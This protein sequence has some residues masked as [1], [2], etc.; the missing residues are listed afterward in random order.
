MARSVRRGLT[1]PDI[2]AVRDRLVPECTIAA[3]FVT[4][5][6][7]D[8]TLGIADA[9]VVDP[10]GSIALVVD[11]KSDVDPAPPTV[12]HY[13]SQVGAYLKATRAQRP[14]RLPDEWAHGTCVS[15]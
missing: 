11:W 6:G 15:R 8:I 7:E 1:L 9:V 14:D 3:S 13:R 10:D 2:Q 5:D 12:A 4:G